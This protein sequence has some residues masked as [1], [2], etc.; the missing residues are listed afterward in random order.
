MDQHKQ[1]IKC[2]FGHCEVLGRYYLRNKHGFYLLYCEKHFIMVKKLKEKLRQKQHKKIK[3]LKY[4][5]SLRK[6]AENPSLKLGGE[7]KS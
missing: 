2:S 3:D 7:M 1:Q 6:G 5:Y 4:L